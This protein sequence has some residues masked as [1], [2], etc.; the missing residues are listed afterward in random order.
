MNEA[1][2]RLIFVFTLPLCLDPTPHPSL[3]KN[4]IHQ[5]ILSL[6]SFIICRVNK[7]AE[8]HPKT[9]L[10]MADNREQKKKRAAAEGQDCFHSYYSVTAVNR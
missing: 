10:Q 3:P 1:Q 2:Q 9:L 6:F 4:R 5:R 7:E 8:R